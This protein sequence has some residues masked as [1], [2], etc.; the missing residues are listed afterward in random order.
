MAAMRREEIG[1]RSLD[2]STYE[3]KSIVR[4]LLRSL[5]TLPSQ[6]G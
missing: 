4:W 2:G 3:A 5:W 1:S 6:C